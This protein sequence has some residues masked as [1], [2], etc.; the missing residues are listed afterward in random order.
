MY[1]MFR[2]HG[3]EGVL[4]QSGCSE[5]KNVQYEVA[6]V[7]EKFSRLSAREGSI[8]RFLRLVRTI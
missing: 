7:V 5:S 2:I 8:G 1:Q 6:V 4:V 3:I